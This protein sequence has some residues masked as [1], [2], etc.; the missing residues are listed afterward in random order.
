MHRMAFLAI[1]MLGLILSMGPVPAKDV[2]DSAAGL[3][4]PQGDPLYGELGGRSGIK[5]VI[6]NAMV[7]FLHDDRI[8]A[9]FRDENIDRLKA[10][11]TDYFCM[12][13]GGPDTY[14]GYR[15][16]K[17]VHAGLHLRDRDLNALVEDLQKAMTAENI[18][19][20]VQNRLLAILAPMQK[21]V[22]SQ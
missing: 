19:F 6:D 17:V 21:D 9:K 16:M 10:M 5:A 4:L 20:P 12:L 8:R 22:V 11:L 13:S 3:A 1:I 7:R 2:Q 18:P 15:D 14:K